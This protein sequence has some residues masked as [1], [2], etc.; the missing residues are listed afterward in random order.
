MFDV[1]TMAYFYSKRAVLTINI[2]LNSVAALG[3]M[4]LFLSMVG[5]YGVVA[6][7]VGRRKREIGLR[8]AIGADKSQVLRM[9]LKQGL[10]LACAGVVVGMLLSTVARPLLSSVMNGAS[11]TWGRCHHGLHRS[12]HAAD[13][14][15]L[16]P[17]RR[18]EEHL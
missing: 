18:R 15:C 5:L 11:N 14:P 10:I 12:S 3:G 7:S 16:L 1:R 13:Y 2:V 17:L 9:V 8:M 4:G 6:F